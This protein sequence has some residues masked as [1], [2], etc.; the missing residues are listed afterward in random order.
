M[1]SPP[2]SPTADRAADRHAGT[3]RWPPHPPAQRPTRLSAPAAAAPSSA[4]D[5]VCGREA[6]IQGQ[7]ERY[8]PY[9]RLIQSGEH[10]A[11][12][13]AESSSS[14]EQAGTIEFFVSTAAASPREPSS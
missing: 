3:H 12:I 9:I 13:S 5:R 2:R 8:S 14:A 1:N 4:C 10:I 7:L 6:R 11:K